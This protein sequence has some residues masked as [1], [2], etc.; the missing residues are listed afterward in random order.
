M[1][2]TIVHDPQGNIMDMVAYPSNAPP[3][4]P[5]NSGGLVSQVEV[6]DLKEELG[7]KKIRA[8]KRHTLKFYGSCDWRESYADRQEMI[9]H[10]HRAISPGFPLDRRYLP[11]PQRVRRSLI[12]RV[13]KPARQPHRSGSAVKVSEM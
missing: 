1:K 5:R 10:R 13:A 2:L 4:Y 9:A 7:A 3:A 12:G 8:A 11:V 6:P